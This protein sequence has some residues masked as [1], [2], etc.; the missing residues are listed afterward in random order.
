MATF[1][2]SFY[3]GIT[4]VLGQG[5]A[6]H[7]TTP[8]GWVVSWLLALFGMGILATITGAVGGFVIDF[9]LR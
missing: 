9:L 4:T 8:L 1:G 6:S 7:V 3:W 2:E 5:D